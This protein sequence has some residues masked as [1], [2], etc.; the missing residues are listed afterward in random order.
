MIGRGSCCRRGFLAGL[1]VCAAV[2]ALA[3]ASAQQRRRRIGILTNQAGDTA[4]LALLRTSLHTL[5]YVEG[6][7][8]EFSY[9]FGEGNRETLRLKAAELV[10][11]GVELI[12]AAPTAAVL[13]AK[14]ATKTIPIVFVGTPDPVGAGLVASFERPGGN[15]TGIAGGGIEFETKRLEILKQAFPRAARLAYLLNAEGEGNQLLI[16]VAEDNASRLGLTITPFG[17]R[18]PDDIERAFAAISSSDFDAV[19]VVSGLVTSLKVD[20]I[21]ALANATGLPAIY[22]EG[23]SSF[24]DSGGLMGLGPDT[25]DGPRRAAELID[26]ILRGAHPADLPV[27]FPT[28]F[29][30]RLNLRTAKALG[31]TI[32]PSLLA[33]ADEVIE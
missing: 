26:K 33:R 10:R 8:V 12:V 20:R 31:L 29:S 14:E 11:S 18:I 32:P 15:V 13:I 16:R 3:P 28:K 1:S 23:N 27:E 25:S 21:T 2:L 22:Q 17:I 19:S 24:V 4:S 9:G 6:S 5:G 30:L 7:T